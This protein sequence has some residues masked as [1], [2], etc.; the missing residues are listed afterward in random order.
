MFDAAD[1]FDQFGDMLDRGLHRGAR[2]GDFAD[3]GGRRRLHRLR[4]AGDVVIGGDHGLGGLLQMAEPLRLTGDA[5][6]DFLQIAGDVGE[7]DAEAADAVGELID[8]PLAVRRRR[9]VDLLA[10]ARL[11]S[12][13]SSDRCDDGVH[14]SVIACRRCGSR[15][16]AGRSRGSA[17]RSRASSRFCRCPCRGRSSGSD[18]SAGC[19]RRPAPR[20]R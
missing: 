19:G 3:G 11:T 20:D 2:L 7:L 14:G 4:G 18:R 15:P 9:H 13:H 10:A 6:G 12:L 16:S 17:R 5:A 8:Q 1:G